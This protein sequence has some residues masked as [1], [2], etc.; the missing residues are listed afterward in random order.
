MFTYVIMSKLHRA[1]D[2]RNSFFYPVTVEQL[3]AVL[4]TYV[5]GFKS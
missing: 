3:K 5:V 2:V 1:M 4:G